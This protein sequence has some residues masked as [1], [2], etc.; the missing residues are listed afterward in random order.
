MKQDPPA[1]SATAGNA[2]TG[3]HDQHGLSAEEQVELLTQ[4]CEVM[5]VRMAEFEELQLE[6]L[7]TLDGLETKLAS[8]EVQGV[9][10]AWLHAISARFSKMVRRRVW[11][12]PKPVDATGS[13]RAGVR[14]LDTTA[15]LVKF[16]RRWQTVLADRLRQ[17]NRSPQASGSAS[18]LWRLQSARRVILVLSLLACS[19][20]LLALLGQQNLRP[21]LQS[22]KAAPV[23]PAA[24]VASP[25]KPVAEPVIRLRVAAP[26]WLEVEAASGKV[27]FYDM[28]RRGTI[29]LPLL[30]SVRIRAGRPDLIRVQ[31]AGK[32]RPLGGINATGWH[33]FSRP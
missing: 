32:D 11:P 26:S 14:C 8:L 19:V 31:L 27:L 22:E 12:R 24:P 4:T 9:E 5:N 29:V 10:Q 20:P 7:Q 28:A 25:P 3:W 15:S 33:Q 16:G 13:S 2:A 1:S 23:L 18:G 30:S 21:V 17:A 6:L